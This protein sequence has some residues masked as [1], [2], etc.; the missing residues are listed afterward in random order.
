MPLPTGPWPSGVTRVLQSRALADGGP[1]VKGPAP[2]WQSAGRA[3]WLKETVTCGGCSSGK[4]HGAS[5]NG[6]LGGDTSP[7]LGRKLTLRI[8]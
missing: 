5:R 8:T 6:L 4:A 7:L 3:G 2:T 1:W